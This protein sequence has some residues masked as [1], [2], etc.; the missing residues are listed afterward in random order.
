MS[1]DE[2]DDRVTQVWRD[3]WDTF[4]IT[5]ETMAAQDETL[6]STTMR[7]AEVARTNA[8]DRLEDYSEQR[9]IQVKNVLGE[10]GMGVV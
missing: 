5:R 2:Q 4:A 9:D 8:A 10:G 3:R 6:Y 1:I 7:S